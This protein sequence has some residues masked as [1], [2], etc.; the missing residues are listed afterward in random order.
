MHCRVGEPEML[1]K[2]STEGPSPGKAHTLTKKWDGL[3]WGT[4]G[5]A[6]S[7]GPPY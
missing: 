4:K 2:I 5:K 6:F 1:V 7:L 3:D